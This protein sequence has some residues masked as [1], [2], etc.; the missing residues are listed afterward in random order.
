MTDSLYSPSWYRVASLK[1]RLR[2]HVQIHRHHYRG[3]LWYVLQDHLS[4]RLQRF[5]PMAYQ[6]I[7][8]MD[9]RR[10]VREIWEFA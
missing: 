6:L 7:G 3:E 2:G 9:C 5:T 1:P 4:G 10:T 8:M